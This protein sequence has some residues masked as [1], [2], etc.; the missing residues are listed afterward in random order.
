M[1]MMRSPRRETMKLCISKWL[2]ACNGR[3]AHIIAKQAFGS[4]WLLMRP[5]YAHAAHAL[6]TQPAAAAGDKHNAHSTQSLLLPVQ[7]SMVHATVAC[8]Y[9]CRN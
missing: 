9:D 2:I 7:Y 3:D 1:R 4:A 5:V 8:V 6:L